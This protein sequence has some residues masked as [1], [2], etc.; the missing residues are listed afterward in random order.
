MRQHPH[1]YVQHSNPPPDADELYIITS[2][3]L[4]RCPGIVLTVMMKNEDIAPHL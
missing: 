3:L 1:I 2:A 4:S